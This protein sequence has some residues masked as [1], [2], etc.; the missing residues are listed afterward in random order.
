MIYKY[1]KMFFK[2][3]KFTGIHQKLLAAALQF[4]LRLPDP[5]VDSWLKT[6]ILHFLCQSVDNDDL[7]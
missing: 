2:G 5:W 4:T 7:L 1:L 3:R 6:L